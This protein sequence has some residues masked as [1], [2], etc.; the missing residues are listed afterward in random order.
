[1]SQHACHEAGAVN[2]NLPLWDL[3]ETPARLSQL[4][5]LAAARPGV[6][7]TVLRVGRWPAPPIL[8]ASAYHGTT[9]G[10]SSS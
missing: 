10:P 3:V 9:A 4:A 2:E 1:M 5:K 7:L 6:V 8:R